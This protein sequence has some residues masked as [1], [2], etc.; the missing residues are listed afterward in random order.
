MMVRLVPDSPQELEEAGVGRRL[1]W[2]R[3]ILEAIGIAL[4]VAGFMVS[5]PP[6]DD[7]AVPATRPFLVLVGLLLFSAGL[8]LERRL[9]RYETNGSNREG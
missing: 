9:A 5:W 7:P 2:R 1:A 6:S 4:I 8:A 3:I